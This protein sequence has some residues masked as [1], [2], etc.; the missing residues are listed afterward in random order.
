MI[1]KCPTCLSTD[2]RDKRLRSSVLIQTDS[3]NIIIDCGPDFRQQMIRCG[4]ERIDGVLVTHEHYDHVGGM[5]DLRPFC[6]AHTIPV[7]AEEL[8]I[9]HLMERIPYCFGQSKY[10][11]TPTLEL[12][13][14][15]PAETFSIGDIDVTPIRVMHG[16]LP[17]VGF[18]IGTLA[19][20]TDMKSIPEESLALLSGV[21]TLVVNALHTKEH[22]THQNVMQA[23]RFSER[24]GASA[25]WFIHMSHRVG[26]HAVVDA[27]L[28]PSMHF[29]YDGLS[30]LL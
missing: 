16:S 17:I 1:C 6:A 18:R 5:D 9:R 8:V 13:Q 4:L 20:I 25:T 10:P 26:M 21:E 24:I 19:Y 28:P 15:R 22:P 3:T 11:G 2:P 30:F 12:K 27:K 7:Y 23:I 14:I 29:A